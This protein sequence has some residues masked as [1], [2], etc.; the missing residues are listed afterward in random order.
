MYDS[1]LIVLFRFAV[2]VKL[3]EDRELSWVAYF[4]P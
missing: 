4:Y 2:L 3:H 1:L